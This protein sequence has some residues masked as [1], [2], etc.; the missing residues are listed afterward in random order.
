MFCFFIQIHFFFL[1]FVK[2]WV[3]CHVDW[4]LIPFYELEN[5]KK[6]YIFFSFFITFYRPEIV[7]VW[8][9][10]YLSNEGPKHSAQ[11]VVDGVS[12]LTETVCNISAQPSKAFTDWVADKI[13]PSY[14]K[15]N[16]EIIV[17]APLYC[18]WKWQNNSFFHS[19]MS[20]IAMRAKRT[21]TEL[22]YIGITVVAVAKASVT[23]VQW[24][25]CRCRREDGLTRFV[26]A[27]HAKIFCRKSVT[28]VQVNLWERTR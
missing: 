2:I 27:M 25:K 6:T 14:W 11:M 20:S 15:Q 21:L 10:S 16:S 18:S 19:M 7:H 3:G 17:S 12:Y 5:D 8:R 24:I 13:A 22:V 4:V 28:L 1:K 9:D 23:H 26:C